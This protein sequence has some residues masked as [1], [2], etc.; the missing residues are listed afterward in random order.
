[1]HE[2]HSVSSDGTRM[3]VRREKSFS[4]IDEVPV[5]TESCVGNEVVL[6][7]SH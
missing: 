1:M 4:R 2:E 3:I 7:T 6:E 5:G